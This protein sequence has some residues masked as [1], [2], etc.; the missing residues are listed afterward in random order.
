MDRDGTINEEIGYL[1]SP[2]QLSLIP[3]AARAIRAFNEQGLV[4]CVISNQSGV[5][6]GFFP[7]SALGP[8]HQALTEK[9]AREGARVDRIYYC[10]HHPVDGIPPYRV[11]CDCRKPLTG[12]LVRG[13]KECGIDLRRSYTVGDRIVDVQAG[14]AAGTKTILV[15]TGYGME[16]VTECEAAGVVPD[17]TV[18][19]LT[20]A[21]A[22]ILQDMGLAGTERTDG[23]PG[24]P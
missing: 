17:L 14:R 19:D 23:A 13:V 8:I 20:E 5:A 3:G 15:L 7:E 16:T 4:T 1:R 18:R 11:T 21:A 24:A 2:E 6:R 22:F 12:M 9:L 10:P